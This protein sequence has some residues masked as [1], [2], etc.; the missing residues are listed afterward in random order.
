ML[1]VSI[2]SDVSNGKLGEDELGKR[3]KRIADKMQYCKAIAGDLVFN[4]TRAW[5]GAIGV[6]QTDGMVSPTHIVAKPN[7][8][9]YPPFMDY[10]MKTPCMI[11]TIH[12]Q[13]Y[14]VTDFRLRPV[15]GFVRAESVHPATYL[16][17]ALDCRD[18]CRSGQGN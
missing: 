16:K 8:K 14:G 18:S 17:A 11:E 13:P 2:H 12:K 7:D 15:L 10:Y 5:Q 1:S 6:V 9:V 4:M 3:I